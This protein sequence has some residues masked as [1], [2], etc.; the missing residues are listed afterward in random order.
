M[1]R[2]G[3]LALWDEARR[4]LAGWLKE[5]GSRPLKALISLSYRSSRFWTHYLS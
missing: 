2:V 4:S 3:G 1:D 5:V